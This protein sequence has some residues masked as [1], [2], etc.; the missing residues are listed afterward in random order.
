MHEVGRFLNRLLGLPPDIQNG[1]VL[2]IT[3]YLMF[4]SFSTR[5]QYDKY[6]FINRLFELFVSIL[7]LLVRN[8][9]IEGNLDT[10]IV[11]LKA[12]V[13]EL[14]GTPKVCL[15]DL[16]LLIYLLF[17]SFLS[18]NYKRNAVFYMTWWFP[19]KPNSYYFHF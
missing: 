16:C 19:D 15:L 17:I 18:I 12:N 7:D 6:H 4:I 2:C 11:D 13:I 9:R 10:G 3:N 5:I 14:Q 8:A 1:C